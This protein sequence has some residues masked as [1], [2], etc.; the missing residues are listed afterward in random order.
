[1]GVSPLPRD[2]VQVSPPGV[3][4]LASSVLATSAILADAH[5]ER[6]DLNP[7]HDYA[8]FNANRVST[9]IDFNAQG[10]WSIPPIILETPFGVMSW[11]HGP[12]PDVRFTLIEGH[13]RLRYLAGVADAG[14]ETGPHELFILRCPLAED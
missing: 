7:A 5:L 2:L 11:D 4:Y 8:S 1:M 12:L 13:T 10:T 9:A 14:V 6:D 3:A